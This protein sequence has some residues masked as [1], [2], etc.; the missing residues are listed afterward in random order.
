[1]LKGEEGNIAAG[2]KEEDSNFV[3]VEQKRAKK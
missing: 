1:M 2:K 3:K